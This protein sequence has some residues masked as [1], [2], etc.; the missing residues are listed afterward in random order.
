VL[1]AFFQPFE[2]NLVLTDGQILPD[3]REDVI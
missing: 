3:A 1:A 2:R